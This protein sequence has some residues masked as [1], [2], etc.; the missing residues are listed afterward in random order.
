MKCPQCG[1]ANTSD[2]KFCRDCAAPLAEPG[3]YILTETIRAPAKELDSGTVF[4]GRYQV[5]EELGRGGM[6]HVYRVLD[7]KL[8]EE[9]ALK[10]IKPEVASDEKTIQRFRNEL[11]TARKIGHPNVTRMYDLGEDEGTHYITMEYV[12]G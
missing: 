6:G 11:K 8:G 5:I 3:E 4:A 10:V 2:S 7:K 12:R 9:V 1:S